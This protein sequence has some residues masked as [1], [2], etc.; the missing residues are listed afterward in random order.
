VHVVDLDHE[1]CVRGATDSYAGVA[2]AR[3]DGAHFSPAGALAVAKWVMPIVLGRK[4]NPRTADETVP[5][6][7]Y[8]NS[9]LMLS[10][11]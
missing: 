4:P 11:L 6:A 8:S 1:L 7:P 10:R 5:P 9:R 2:D 3:Y